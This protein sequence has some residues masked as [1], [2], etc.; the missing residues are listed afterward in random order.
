MTEENNISQENSNAKEES[1]NTS[2]S[3]SIESIK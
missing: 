1:L 2:S 3:L